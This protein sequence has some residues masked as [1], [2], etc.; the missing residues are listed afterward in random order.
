MHA[1]HKQNIKNQIKITQSPKKKNK[2]L[3]I[4]INNMLF[5]K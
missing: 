2:K 1:L 3:N 4:N 5:L